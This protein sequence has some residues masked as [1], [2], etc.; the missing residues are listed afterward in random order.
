MSEQEII[1]WITLLGIIII[2]FKLD[3]LE[4][5]I[6]AMPEKDDE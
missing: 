4:R 6:K 5:L 1:G 2:L 3:S